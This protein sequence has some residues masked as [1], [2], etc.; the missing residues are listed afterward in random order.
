[1]SRCAGSTPSC[2]ARRTRHET[3][4][5][6]RRA[7]GRR[8]RH[9]PARRDRD[10]ERHAPARRTTRAATCS[11]RGLAAVGIELV[12][13]RLCGDDAV[14]AD[15]RDPGRDRRRRRRRA[16]H[17]RHRASRR[18]T[19]RPR[20]CAPL[21]RPRRCPDSASGSARSRSPR[22]ARPPG[23]RAPRPG[24]RGAAVVFRCPARR[25]PVELAL[26][27]LILP[28]ARPR[29][30]LRLP[31]PNAE[32]RGVK[33]AIKSD[34]WI[35]KMCREHRMIEPF[36]EKQVRAGR[37]SP[38]ASR[39]TATTSASPTSSRS[40]PTSTRTIVDPE[41]H[42]PALDGRLQGRR[43]RSSRRTRSRSGAPSSTS[44]SRAT[45]SRSASASPPTRAAASS[46]TSRRS[47]PSG[48]ASSTLEISNT[49]PLPAKIYANEGIAQVLFFESDEPC[50]MSYADKAGKYQAQTGDHAA[51]AVGTPP[52]ARAGRGS[53]PPARAT[54]P[55][56][57]RGAA[58]PPRGVR[59]AHRPTA[60]RR[61]PRARGT[62]GAGRAR[63]TRSRR[64][65]RNRSCRSAC[66]RPPRPHA[67]ASS[68]VL[69]Q[70]AFRSAAT[71]TS[72]D[73]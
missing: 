22:S 20:R 58:P 50:E 54:R 3:E 6:R 62:T 33:H 59:A 5:R 26:E 60:A 70:P 15:A 68:A 18:A 73:A 34:R 42:R 48:R 35:R 46:R 72:A 30:P 8:G 39:P 27:R 56:P 7:P 9:R 23:S 41:A 45:C 55:R 1:M 47:S 13:R 4:P 57:D 14:C 11:P 52:R 36:E 17:R 71:N 29:R 66:T 49:T 19:S 53:S 16:G 10:R 65:A 31:G 24:S 51:A 43:S 37:R 25:A 32:P 12:D 67:I 21:G 44:A 61:E 2:P 40:S 63:P 38:T 28:E 64:G 69:H